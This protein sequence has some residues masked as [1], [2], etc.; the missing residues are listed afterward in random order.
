MVRHG[1][2]TGAASGQGGPL[3]TAARGVLALIAASVLVG[4]AACGSAVAGGAGRPVSVGASFSTERAAAVRASAGVALCAAVQK[5]DRVVVSVHAS[6][7]REI[8]PRGITIRDLPRVRALAA[9]VCALPPV[10]P[11]LHCRAASVGALGLVFTA[12]SH[13]FHL[14]RIQPSGCR[15]VTGVGPVRWWSRSPQ[16]GRLLGGML[17]GQGSLIPARQPSSVPTP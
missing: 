9:M 10:P 14:V 6:H 16:F 2:P 12:G 13:G 11:G 5:V 8:L 15:T 17:G 7:F 4:L 3:G 1:R